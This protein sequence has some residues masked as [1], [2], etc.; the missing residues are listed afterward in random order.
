MR[1]GGLVNKFLRDSDGGPLVEFTLVFPVLILVALGTVD[2]V[3]MMFDWNMANK[4]AFAGARTAVVTSPVASGIT[5]VPYNSTQQLNIGNWCFTVATGVVDSGNCPTFSTVCTPN[6]TNGSCTA[7]G[8]TTY[9]WNETAFATILANMQAVFQKTCYGSPCLQRQNVLISYQSN[10]LGFSGR[11]N[12]LPMN[13]TVSIR[14]MTH[15]FFFISGLMS[16]VFTAPPS[17][18]PT[19]IPAGPPIPAFAT[20]LT[21]EGMGFTN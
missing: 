8:S 4:A 12:G 13:V 3:S 17:P 5:T 11:P 18:C 19:G 20:T 2:W 15:E 16:W 7:S 6:T 1:S 21:S 14:C 9:T 10:G